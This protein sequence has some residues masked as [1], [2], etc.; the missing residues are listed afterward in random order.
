MPGIW[1]LLGLLVTVTFVSAVLSAHWNVLA[2]RRTNDWRRR[3]ALLESNHRT[4][5]LLGVPSLL[6]LSVFANGASLALGYQVVEDGWLQWL[7]ATWVIVLMLVALFD[8]AT[9]RR[10]VGF[11]RSAARGGD[12]SG[13]DVALGRWR[14]S[15]AML[16]GSFLLFLTLMVPRWRF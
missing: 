9:G 3:A 2:A 15:S 12:A 11:A 13:F 5:L 8:L 1:K 14:I 7:N 4:A 10:L 16:L 6:L